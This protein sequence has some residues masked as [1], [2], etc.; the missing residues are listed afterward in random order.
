MAA[1][2]P[3][4]VSPAKIVPGPPASPVTTAPAPMPKKKITIMPT[5]L[6]RSPSQ[7]AGNAATPYRMRPRLDRLSSSPYGRSKTCGRCSTAVA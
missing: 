6:Q 7:P 2:R 1:N 4:M 3:I 5:W